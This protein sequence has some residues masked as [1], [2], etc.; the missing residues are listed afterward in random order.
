MSLVIAVK[1]TEGVVLSADSRLTLT[2]ASG[3]PATFDNA[4]KLLTFQEPHNWVGALTYGIAT[5][6]G[7]TPH[8]LIP[9]FEATLGDQRL[10]VYEYATRLS[11]FFQGGWIASGAVSTG[12]NANFYVGG[13]DIDEAYGRIYHFGVPNLPTPVECNPNQFGMSWGGQTNIVSRIIL[14]HD[15]QLLPIVSQH[16]GLIP[17]QQQELNIVLGK[18]AYN[19][20][21]ST[22]ALQDCIDLAT[23]LIRATVS[24]QRLATELRGVGGQIDV[25]TITR[26]EGFQWVQKKEIRG[27]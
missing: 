26:M 4:T 22:L 12:D 14:G 21:L 24:A 19:I 20:P 9:E 3:I 7:Q 8:S 2:T 16:L 23:Y 27:G 25:A 10:T 6:G 5:I 17:Q 13:Y 11:A 1:G 18:L 15:P